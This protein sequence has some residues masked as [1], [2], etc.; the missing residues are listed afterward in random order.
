M[1]DPADE[2]SPGRRLAGA[3]ASAVAAG[4]AAALAP[5]GLRGALALLAGVAGLWLT[6]ALPL[7]VTALIVPLAA[8]AGGLASPTQALVP[9]AN[10]VIFLFLGGFA[11]AAALQQQG[12]DLALAARVKRLAGGR[13][14]GSV[15]ALAGLTA[16]LS[17]W[18][19]N[20]ATTAMVLPLALGLLADDG[21]APVGER[22]R[23]FVLLALAYSASIGGMAT[24]VGSPPNAI[25]AA[26]AGIGFA[27]WMA[28]GLPAALLA[29]PLM[30]ALLAWRLKPQ[31]RGR[32]PVA[33]VAWAW[34]PARRA[35][36]GV[37][38]LTVAGWLGGA[39]LAAALGLQADTDAL[40]AL[41]ALVALVA[42]GALDWR[43]LERS[44]PWGVLL[45]FG[46][47]LSLSALM[48]A[49]GASAHLAALLFGAVAGWPAWLLLAA[50]IAFVVFLTEV[51][52]NTASAALLLPVLLPLA[53]DLGL[54][55]AGTAAAVALAAS[56]AFMLPVATPPNALVYA[57][58][59][60]PAAQMLRQGLWLNGLAIVLLTALA[61]WAWT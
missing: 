9:F 53:A 25:A 61:G 18:M 8:M 19:S 56:C 37:F 40:V 2:F 27:Q 58:E 36:V 31:L 55:A 57:T 24:L 49:S 1:S 59:R 20:T 45:L 44:A 48:Q 54:P 38:V 29:W 13:R 42:S 51:V 16:L 21:D 15:L 4:A 10:P 60:V 47:G 39:P 35:T 6:R 32:V 5:E 50:V 3:L 52:S 41:A 14:L 26:Q 23:V 46:G 43:A 7:P 30:L 22:E 34:T 11:L 28:Y 12:L 33:R 17:M